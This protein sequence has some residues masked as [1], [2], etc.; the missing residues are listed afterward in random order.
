MRK[1]VSL[2]ASCV[3]ITGMLVTWA[4]SQEVN[5]GSPDWLKA[6]WDIVQPLVMLFVSIVGPVLVSWLAY[7]IVS[8]LNIRDENEQKALELK[9]RDA[10]HQSALN[11]LKYAWAKSGITDPTKITS[12]E[13]IK[14]AV[15]YIK[16]KN[17][18]TVE[19]TGLSTD[20][21]KDI[22]LSKVPD[23]I[24]MVLPGPVG[25]IA[26]AIVGEVLEKAKAP[27]VSTKGASKIATP[28]Q[29]GK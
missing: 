15:E 18:E 10:L 21:L 26:G 20:G 22:V 17:P 11:A 29:E 6:V 14:T 12:P 27:K 4:L 2:F 8:F 7:K 24:G 28:V 13:V 1:I 23:V 9:I 3:V 16:D 5:A 19:K 25:G